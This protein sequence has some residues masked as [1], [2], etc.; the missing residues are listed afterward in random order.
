MIMAS[1]R[2]ITLAG[3]SLSLE[4]VIAVSQRQASV[5]IDRTVPAR[6]RY[7]P[8]YIERALQTAFT[9][10]DDEPVA[11]LKSKAVY[12]VSTGFGALKGNFIRS[13][14]DARRLQENIVISHA[15][16][17]GVPLDDDIVRAIMLIR[18]HVL[19]SGY[20]GARH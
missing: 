12:G 19:A 16:G 20:C 14:S 7:A 15:A 2:R 10:R 6:L 13:D 1:S 8:E 4:D 11:T 18:A 3:S 9:I 5:E 17:V